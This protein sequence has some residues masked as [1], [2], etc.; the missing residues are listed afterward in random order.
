MFGAIL[1]RN[2]CILLDTSGSMGPHLQQVKTELILLIWEQLRKRCDRQEVGVG[3][4]GVLGE[5][6]NLK[7]AGSLR[8]SGQGHSLLI[9][10]KGQAVSGITSE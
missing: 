10:P 8:G 7:G 6:R 2:V 5:L 9:V 1:E 3:V 4:V